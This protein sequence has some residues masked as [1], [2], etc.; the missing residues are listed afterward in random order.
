MVEQPPDVA[1]NSSYVRMLGR[2]ASLMPHLLDGLGPMAARKPPAEAYQHILACDRAM[3][4]NVAKIPEFLLREDTAAG[5]HSRNAC[6]PWLPLARR[7]L[8]I[9]AAEKTIMIHRPV[10]FD[11]FQS[12]AFRLTR[13]TCVA[14]ATTIL[15]EHEQAV[16]E[17][18]VSIWTHSAFCV[19]AAVVLGLEL[20]HRTDH[21]DDLAHSYR[22]MLLR[23]ADRLRRRHADAIAERGALLI[24]TMLAAEE[25]LVLRMMRTA[26]SA[27][28]TTLEEHQRAIINDMIGSH[29][30]MARFLAIA[31][32]RPAGSVASTPLGGGG[33]QTLTTSPQ[34]Q[35]LSLP[36]AGM[37]PSGTAPLAATT[38]NMGTGGPGRDGDMDTLLA[39]M[40]IDM[41]QDFESWF[42][43]V[44]APV[45][46]PLV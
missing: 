41:G 36:V 26:R 45:Y 34:A 39:A 42:N 40:D 20:F 21:T 1:T 29:E 33:V 2:T 17:Q 10:L 30:I 15:R 23:A 5:S 28:G 9:S 18:A 12:A 38:S 13:T 8:A 11:S 14:A 35:V 27:S 44:F 32:Q 7:T 19:T 22:Q 37:A 16:S 46:D 4:A 6:V 3:R 24:D 43:N 25:D 31:P